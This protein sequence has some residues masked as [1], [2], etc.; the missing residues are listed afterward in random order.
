MPSLVKLYREFESSGFVV[1]AVSIR[2]DEAAV[3][4]YARN[5]RLPFPVLLDPAG[6]VASAYGAQSTPMHYLIDRKGH[7]VALIQGARDWT[8]AELRNLVQYFLDKN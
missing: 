8:S 2:D 5:H 1:L 7:A 6:D 3:K 4:E